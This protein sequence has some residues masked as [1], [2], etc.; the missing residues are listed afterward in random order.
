MT[1]CRSHAGTRASR[2]PF[3]GSRHGTA[4]LELASMPCTVWRQSLVKRAAMTQPSS[5]LEAPLALATVEVSPLGRVW[6]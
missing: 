4:G 6:R 3:G 5:N 2:E 1:G